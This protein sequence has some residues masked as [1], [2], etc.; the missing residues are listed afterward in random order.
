MIYLHIHRNIQS[1]CQNVII[2]LQSE[3]KLELNNFH[4]KKQTSINNVN[5]EQPT[6]C[7]DRKHPR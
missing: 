3:N 1:S 7:Q 4:R 6:S 2:L 5:N